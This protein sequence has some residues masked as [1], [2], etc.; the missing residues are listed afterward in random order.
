MI[1][2]FMMMYAPQ[3]VVAGAILFLFVYAVK[4]KDSGD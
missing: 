2:H 3:L 1:E 4:Y